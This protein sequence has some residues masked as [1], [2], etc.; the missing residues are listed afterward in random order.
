[1]FFVVVGAEIVRLMDILI[2]ELHGLGEKN[3][4]MASIFD[5][6][7]QDLKTGKVVVPGDA[8]YDDSLKRWSASCIKPAV[9]ISY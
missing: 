8:D 4:T 1:M 7:K 6:L 3:Q 5:S 2:D 9:S